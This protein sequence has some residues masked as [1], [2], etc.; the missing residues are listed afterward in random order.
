[1]ITANYYCV[2]LCA[3]VK[4]RNGCVCANTSSQ[5]VFT[6]FGVYYLYMSNYLPLLTDVN[7]TTLIK[8]KGK[9]KKYKY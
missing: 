6:L 4:K 1:M 8:G 9:E 7:C 2:V 5:P 3:T